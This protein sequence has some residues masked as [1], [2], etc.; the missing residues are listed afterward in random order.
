MP[1]ARKRL[2]DEQTLIP[3][4]PDKPGR[5]ERALDDALRARRAAGDLGD[6]RSEDVAAVRA[7][8]TVARQLDRAELKRDLWATA[9]LMREYRECLAMIGLDPA[10]RAGS[11]D[12]EAEDFIRELREASGGL[13]GPGER[14][15]AVGDTA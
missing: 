15:S 6:A 9:T 11:A 2:A 7:A 4:G 1:V 5:V 8:Q 10:R 14:R 13:G 12:S 3:L